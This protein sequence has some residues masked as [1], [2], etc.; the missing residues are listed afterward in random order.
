MELYNKYKDEIT[1]LF[2]KSVQELKESRNISIASIQRAIGY[3]SPQA[4]S[5]VMQ[6]KTM[7]GEKYLD[8]YCEV[9]G[10]NKNYFLP[11]MYENDDAP[12]MVSESRPKYENSNASR[13]LER[14][15]SLEKTNEMFFR[16]M[17]TGLQLTKNN[18]LN[19]K[20]L[21]ELIGV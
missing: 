17:E 16:M 11:Y 7:V 18:A 3:K 14:F 21:R 6:Q 10:F 15:E 4:I 8:K 1:A 2:V 20:D 12:A 5:Q 9:Y 19:F 13:I